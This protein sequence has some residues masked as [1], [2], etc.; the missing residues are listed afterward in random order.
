MYV[1][2]MVNNT[3]HHTIIYRSV[4]SLELLVAPVALPIC[5]QKRRRKQESGA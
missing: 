2:T 5:W 4:E 1:G 3:N